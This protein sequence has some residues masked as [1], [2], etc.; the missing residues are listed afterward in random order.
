[1][2]V[3]KTFK[4]ILALL[5]I[6]LILTACAKK[7]D[8]KNIHVN[9]YLCKVSRG[10]KGEDPYHIV[11]NY[12]VGDQMRIVDHQK[13]EEEWDSNT[14]YSTS[15]TYDW[16]DE[17][18]QITRDD[19]EFYKIRGNLF[20]GRENWYYLHSIMS[21]K[22]DYLEFRTETGGW[23]MERYNPNNTGEVR[24]RHFKYYGYTIGY[25]DGKYELIKSPLADDFREIVDEYPYYSPKC[26]ESVYQYF[27]FKKEDLPNIR[28]EDIN[29]YGQPDL[30]N[31]DYYRKKSSF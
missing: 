7:C 16:T 4:S 10:Y 3:K 20:V 29:P 12:F 24:L 28:I 13:V 6:P 1:M 25:K 14:H 9:K 22:R 18:F 27:N 15:I 23:V 26:Y 8:I 11:V 30:D 17:S 19:E 2:E 5:P 31:W 21:T